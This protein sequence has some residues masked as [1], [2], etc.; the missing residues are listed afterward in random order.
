MQLA[1]VLQSLC[2]HQSSTPTVEFGRSY[3]FGVRDGDWVTIFTDM[4][5]RTLD[6][7][8]IVNGGYSGYLNEYSSNKLIEVMIESNSISMPIFSV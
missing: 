4:L 3:L 8:Q 5:S 1:S 6:K 2:I 7:L